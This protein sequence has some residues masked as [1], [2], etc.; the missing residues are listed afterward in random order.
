[1]EPICTLG[2]RETLSAQ[3]SRLTAPHREQRDNGGPF[4]QANKCGSTCRLK[5]HGCLHGGVYKWSRF[6]DFCD[7]G[8]VV[9]VRALASEVVV[10]HVS[11]MRRFKVYPGALQ[12]FSHV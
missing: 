4:G 5:C 7:I 6:I 3:S 11:A 9:T 2:V 12:R 1:M 10:Q 8:R